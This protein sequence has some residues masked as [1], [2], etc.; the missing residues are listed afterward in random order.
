M[1][2]IKVDKS[3]V[4]GIKMWKRAEIFLTIFVVPPKLIS[5]PR[6]LFILAEGETA[7]CTCVASGVPHP[8]VSWYYRGAEVPSTKGKVSVS[9]VSGHGTLT[10]YNV[11][12]D[13][14]G[15]YIC[16]ISDNLVKKTIAPSCTIKVRGWLTPF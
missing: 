9:S 5:A 6:S 14:S 10:I 1:K 15:N 7:S 3:S 13:D 11:G 8:K 4:V 2:V 12:E 16:K